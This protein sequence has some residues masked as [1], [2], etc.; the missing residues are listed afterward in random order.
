MKLNR[1]LITLVA[2]SILFDSNAKGLEEVRITTGYTFQ[3]WNLTTIS[4][5]TFQQSSVPLNASIRLSR[6]LQFDMDM[7]F[8]H[9]ANTVSEQYISGLTNLA[10]IATTEP[11]ENRL[12][13]AGGISLP[14][15]KHKLTSGELSV[16]EKLADEDLL[17]RTDNYGGGTEGLLAFNAAVPV[18][19]AIEIGLS[20]SATV[21]GGYQLEEES[22]V[23]FNPGEFFVA[24]AGLSSSIKKSL[25]GLDVTARFST[26][27]KID[28]IRQFRVGPMFMTELYYKAELNLIDLNI[29][30][31][32]LSIVPSKRPGSVPDELERETLNSQGVRAGGTASVKFKIKPMFSTTLFIDADAQNENEYNEAHEL[33]DGKKLLIGGGVLFSVNPI[34]KFSINLGFGYHQGSVGERFALSGG[35]EISGV[36]LDLGL[37]TQ[38]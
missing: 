7:G 2:I 6:L 14:T 29:S 24:R 34:S 22:T 36:D 16:A 5:E 31:Y 32:E 25:F 38:F 15:G 1:F 30:A 35:K 26:C 28:G 8:S 18:N 21:R 9:S 17:F 12:Q 11:L 4:E 20:G 10:V 3:Q 37:S 13:I 19:D 27:N 23:E 33:Y